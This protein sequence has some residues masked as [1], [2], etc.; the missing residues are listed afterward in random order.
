MQTPGVGFPLKHGETRTL[1][2][3][4]Q[5]LVVEDVCEVPAD[6]AIFGLVGHHAVCVQGDGSLHSE[7][8]LIGSFTGAIICTVLPIWLQS[9]ADQIVRVGLQHVEELALVVSVSGGKLI[10]VHKR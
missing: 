7:A 2:I 10:H 9:I 3:G 1:W 5:G 4:A 6:I 8:S